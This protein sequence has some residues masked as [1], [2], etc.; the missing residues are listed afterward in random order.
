MYRFDGVEDLG[1]LG[2]FIVITSPPR[3]RL[4]LCIFDTCVYYIIDPQC[5]F[6][7]CTRHDSFLSWI[8]TVFLMAMTSLMESNMDRQ[9][10]VGSCA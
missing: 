3:L 2:D 5:M 8:H 4:E 6:G 1:I 7:G 9:F 10:I